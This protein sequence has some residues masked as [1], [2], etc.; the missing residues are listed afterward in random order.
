MN[1]A[2]DLIVR[3]Q[4]LGIFDQFVVGNVLENTSKRASLR[5][6]R[7]HRDDKKTRCLYVSATSTAASSRAFPVVFYMGVT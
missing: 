3:V 1:T 5:M 4:M 7:N 6:Q 2:I